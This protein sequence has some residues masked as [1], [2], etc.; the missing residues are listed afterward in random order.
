MSRSTF[1]DFRESRIPQAIGLC[2]ADVPRLLQFCNAATLRLVQ[3][4]GETGW[5]GGWYKTVFNVESTGMLTL[6]RE[7]ARVINLAACQTPM[8]IE[9]QFYEFLEASIGPQTETNTCTSGCCFPTAM[10]DRGTVPLMRDIDSTNQKL[11]IYLTDSRDAGKRV[12]FKGIDQ[13]LRTIHSLDGTVDVDGLFVTLAAPFVDTDSIYASVT[14][15]IKDYTAGDVLVYQVDVTTGAQVLLSILAPNEQNPSYRRYELRNIP[16]NCCG[17]AG[18]AQVMGIAKLEYVP[19][20]SDTDFLI[21]GNLEAMK[22]EVMS[23][24]NEEKDSVEGAQK[25]A[26]N[27]KHAI[28]LLQNELRHYLGTN[29]P[30]VVMPLW[31]T[32]TLEKQSIGTLI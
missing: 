8:R 11:R 7:V 2:S 29:R 27:H 13:N 20:F 25:A 30:A 6:P 32:A 3:A 15:V 23:I 17:T 19:V 31:G 28:K 1:R 10:Y 16:E 9:N 26:I 14:G 18:T 22:H 12:L 4:G 5:W 24:W 21:V